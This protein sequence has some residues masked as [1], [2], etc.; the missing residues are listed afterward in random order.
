MYD[1]EV[2]K[3]VRWVRERG[4]REVLV[5]APDGIKPYLAPLLE[6][7]EEEGVEPLVSASHAWG[8]CDLA[9]SEARALGVGAIIHVGHHGPV[10]VRELA[11]DTLFIPA[12]AEVDPAPALERGLA[13]AE[14]EG[15]RRIVLLCS[16][17]HLRELPR[18]VA[19]A[20]RSGFEVVRAG[21]AGVPGL[22][23]GCDPSAAPVDADGV[24]V[25]SGGKFHALGAALA[26]SKPTVAIDPFTQRVELLDREVRKVVA[27]RLSHL[28]EALEARSFAVVLSI[29]PGQV[30]RSACRWAVHALRQAGKR[31]TVVVVNDVSREVLENV[32]GVDAFVNTACPR[33][34]TDDAYLFP[35]PVVNVG[36]LRYLL[37]GRLEDYSPRSVFSLHPAP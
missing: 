1:L 16:V 35:G 18:M 33:L 12:Y 22:I 31:V 4:Y 11:F 28:L 6:A 5:Q 8:G 36:E 27:L 24:L 29:K 2:D 30:N 34:A 26:S 25:V 32:S 19:L 15:F 3:A 21:V 14:D 9:F 20:A 10:R 37:R 23:I 13:L 7:L 17:Q